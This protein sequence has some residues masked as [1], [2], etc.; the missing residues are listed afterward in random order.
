LL[1]RKGL[2]FLSLPEGKNCVVFS[3]IEGKN[4]CTRRREIDALVTAM[5][6]LDIT[7]GTIVTLDQEERVETDA[8][9]IYI[10]AAWKF[11]LGL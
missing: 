9:I 8:G 7:T 5:K 10:V 6:E 11:F 3:F 4:F 2:P 1:L